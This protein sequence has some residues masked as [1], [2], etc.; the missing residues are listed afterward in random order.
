MGHRPVAPA[1]VPPSSIVNSTSNALPIGVDVTHCARVARFEALSR[2]ALGQNDSIVRPDYF[3]LSPLAWICRLRT[4][5]ISTIWT[6]RRKVLTSL[7][8]E[9]YT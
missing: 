6:N 2:Y 5:H 3:E 8:T 9:L 7:F 1:A 4:S